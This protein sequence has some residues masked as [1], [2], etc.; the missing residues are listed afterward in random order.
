MK[1]K[2]LNWLF[3]VC[4]FAVLVCVAGPQPVSAIS[5]DIIISLDGTDVAMAV[6][7]RYKNG[8]IMVPVKALTNALGGVSTDTV[9][10][11][12]SYPCAALNERGIVFATAADSYFVLPLA[13]KDLPFQSLDGMSFS[14]L[15]ELM[16]NMIF[17]GKIE[18][19]NLD[20]HYENVP[21][22]IYLPLD[23]YA[24][25]FRLN[26]TIDGEQ[27]DFKR[28]YVEYVK[29]AFG[30][31]E[32][33][34]LTFGVDLPS[35]TYD[36]KQYFWDDNTLNIYCNGQTFTGRRPELHYTYWDVGRSNGERS[37]RPPIQ[38]G[39]YHLIITVDS[40]DAEYTG[41]GEFPFYIT[42]IEVVLAA[43]DTTITA[44][45][46]LP[47]LPFDL[48][49]LID[50]SLVT[51]ALVEE[52]YLTVRG[53]VD[54]LSTA[55][56]YDIIISGGKAAD[57]YTIVDRVGAKLIVN[58]ADSPAYPPTDLPAE[59]HE[60]YING[61][62]DG[63]FHP[64]APLTRGACAVMLYKISEVPSGTGVAF[65]DVPK[66]AWYYKA[67]QNLAAAGV[68]Q[69]YTDRTFQPNN[70]ITRAEFVSMTLRLFK[71]ETEDTGKRFWDV[72]DSFWGAEAIQAAANLGIISGY[73]DGTFRP[74][75][76][77]T[78]A[79]AVSI[80]NRIT[81][82]DTCGAIAYKTYFPDVS[83]KYWAYDAILRAANNHNHG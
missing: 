42:E 15:T 68:I 30:F 57:N 76:S 48:R 4:I 28:N 16:T 35:K 8:T 37:S 59:K 17:S 56:V 21:G 79:E 12:Y 26:Y 27:V 40:N 18:I 41:T 82:R 49:K 80:L 3:A 7:P 25:M 70:Y 74:G 77:I 64:E 23:T 34:E 29:P 36:G 50:N 20:F 31:S 61:Y 54:K 69:G 78:R 63:T 43:K 14:A 83:S 45:D 19:Y 24:E 47:Y 65:S 73:A 38:A 13:P 67:V 46:T 11:R 81:G 71:T 72:P 6:Q 1:R 55:G 62:E 39:M 52:P 5:G 51:N 58:E 2:Y 75:Q 10:T 33:Q 9:V 22:D 60:A 66:G 32:K 44:G 53:G